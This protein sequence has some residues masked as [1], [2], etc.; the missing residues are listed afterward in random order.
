MAEDEG[1]DCETNCRASSVPKCEEET[2]RQAL[3]LDQIHDADKEDHLVHK[4]K[5]INISV[6]CITNNLSDAYQDNNNSDNVHSPLDLNPS[7]LKVTVSLEL[8]TPVGVTG[9]TDSYSPSILMYK[10]TVYDRQ[11]SVVHKFTVPK[12]PNVV[13]CYTSC[14]V[15]IKSRQLIQPEALGISVELKSKA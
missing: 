4:P 3:L 14:A 15:R 8:Q 11:R 7:R 10:V 13:G 9:K 1:V 2:H 5:T 6:S 12:L